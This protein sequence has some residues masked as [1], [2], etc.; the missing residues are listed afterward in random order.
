[1]LS[2][3]NAVQLQKG[4]TGSR[5]RKSTDSGL[6]ISEDLLR[7]V[8]LKP[9]SER[10][11]RPTPTTP[12]GFAVSSSMLAGI[13]LRST[14]RNI[15]RSSAPSSNTGIID[16]AEMKRVKLRA[17]PLKRSPGGTPHRR[18]RSFKHSPSNKHACLM[19]AIQ[20]KFQGNTD[21]CASKTLPC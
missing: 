11:Q 6:V 10:K 17:T 13:K 18:R 7:R 2:S 20:S 14:G 15:G 8:K 1:M 19:K 3:L 12:G 4:A 5:K 21:M 9:A 16:F